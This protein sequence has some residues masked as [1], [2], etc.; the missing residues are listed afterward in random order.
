MNYIFNNFRSKYFI[1]IYSSILISC[2]LFIITDSLKEYLKILDNADSNDVAIYDD[3]AKSKEQE[4]LAEYRQ[5]DPKEHIEN[6]DPVGLPQNT[7]LY[8]IIATAGGKVYSQG[9]YALVS[10]PS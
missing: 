1:V 7:K 6:I 2:A 9:D 8:W 5:F 10:L 4:T 3:F